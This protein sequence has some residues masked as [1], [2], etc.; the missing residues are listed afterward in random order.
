[1]NYLYFVIYMIVG[2]ATALISYGFLIEP[3]R[4]K[5]IHYKI[6]LTG[7]PEQWHGRRIVFL[8]DIHAGPFYP[9]SLF[10]KAV[11][12]VQKQKPDI[13]LIGGDFVEERTNFKKDGF[14][15]D[16]VAELSRLKAPL[17]SYAIYGNHDTEA[18]ENRVYVHDLLKDAG[19]TLLA[20]EAVNIDGIIL[21]GLEESYHQ[22]PNLQAA[23]E[24]LKSREND[25]GGAKGR[26]NVQ[27]FR[28]GGT[29]GQDGDQNYGSGDTKGQDSLQGN[30]QSDTLT[31]HDSP[32]NHP[33]K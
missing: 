14:R 26:D 16:Y 24:R 27:N 18:S 10:A 25:V 15:S 19:I 13:V 21:V 5:L 9:P 8:S 28:S 6:N 4:L 2:I 22:K 30:S 7:L 23:L 3:R 17:G 32:N 12:A 20:N 31:K 1:M 11:N 33:Q 29:T